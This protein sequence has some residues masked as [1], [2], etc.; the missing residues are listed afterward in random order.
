M[1]TYIGPQGEVDAIL[2]DHD[3]T[4]L[5]AHKGDWVVTY[6]NGRKRVVEAR[7]FADHYKQKFPKVVED[8]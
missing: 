6:R 3:R 1:A 5:V 2:L 4:D 7:Y 8:K